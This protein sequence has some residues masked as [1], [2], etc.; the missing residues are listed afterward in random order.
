MVGKTGHKEPPFPDSIA[1][2]SPY[3]KNQ[4]ILRYALVGIAL[5]LCLVICLSCSKEAPAVLDFSVFYSHAEMDAIY[6]SA[7]QIK[8]LKSVVPNHSF[9]PAPPISNRDYWNKIANGESGKEYLNKAISE[10]EEEPEVPITDEIYR[11]AN[12]EGN[13][14]IYKPR[15]YRTMERLE[16]FIL[17]ECLEDEGRFLPQIAVYLQAIMDMKSWLHPNHDNRENDVL[18]GRSMAIDLGARKFGTDLA[19]AEVLLG[20]KLPDDLREDMS[21]ELQRRIIDC[22]LKSSSGEQ[23]SH[24]G[25]IRSTSNW[26]TV[27]TS[28]SMFVTISASK[29]ADERLAAV[30]CALNSMKFYLKGFGD[31][32][33]CSEGVGYWDYGFG[34][35][36]YLAQILYDYTEGRIN[37][38]D[39]GNP[40]K[41]I[42]VGNFP[43][44][45]EI[46]NGT[47]APFSDGSSRVSTRAGFASIMSAKH[48]GAR[49]P[50]RTRDPERRRGSEARRSS[51]IISDEAAYQLIAWEDPES[52]IA[53]TNVD[54]SRQELPDYTYF[55]DVGM[56]ISRGK[57]E[58]PF[59]IAV[60]AG[61]NA[62]NHNHMDVGTY[63]IVLDRDFPSGDIGAP[64]YIAGAF[65]DDNPARSSWGHPVPR[66]DNKLQSKG[67]DFSGK[68]TAT[69]F[70]A[71]RD[72]V[73]MDILAAYDIPSLT[74]LIRT[75]EN[76]KTGQGSI[77]IVD[78]FSSSEPIAFGTAIMTL[79]EYEII[80]ANTIILTSESQKL[81][82][83]IL[84]EGASIKIIDELVPVEHLREGAPA[85][86]IGI[87]F[88]EPISKG[89]I[90]VRYT[91]VF[92]R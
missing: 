14:G 89:K 87:D 61:H 3:G 83:E 43:E 5:L 92:S 15:Y 29:D 60:K 65:S 47:C 7:K 35:Y 51:K 80:D 66:I 13:R 90:T 16:N 91:P 34:H 78:E 58:V 36:L 41:I 50:V 86:R 4:K 6:P 23:K 79:A 11:R 77:T 71:D 2:D 40:E 69:E 64:S 1:P 39:A 27:C 74:K 20:D 56:V 21:H 68:I 45:Y 49:M 59:S 72:K 38:F 28:G 18:E 84:A 63:T 8:M 53:D 33:Y 57:Q 17:A 37:L 55:D 30:G 22:Y 62:E 75:M 46:Q 26:N 24:L 52:F 67:R 44:R 81:K 54:G 19:F 82:A 25:W 31:D 10:L 42:N 9:Q 76:D 88:T 12:L 48:L 70:T 85:Y 32:G 73:V